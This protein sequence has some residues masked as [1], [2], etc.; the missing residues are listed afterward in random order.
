MK[1]R[2]ILTF[3]SLLALPCA[4]RAQVAGLPIKPG[5]WEDTS[6]SSML[7]GAPGG[8]RPRTTQ[9]C[10]T[11]SLSMDDYLNQ[12]LKQTPGV[13]CTMS[14]RVATAHSVTVD[15]MCTATMNG[16]AFKTNGHI[17][18]EIPDSEHI[19]SKTHSTM[20]GTMQG[21]PMDMT[22]DLTTSAKFIS[23]DCGNVKPL[24][25]PQAK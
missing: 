13:Q 20:S 8:A 21:R 9:V 3:T 14:N 4:L 15:E 19:S 6:T 2:R 1:V 10:Y 5:L 17:V 25:I 18:L 23:S 16:G 24:A 22:L 12:L 11:A 7:S